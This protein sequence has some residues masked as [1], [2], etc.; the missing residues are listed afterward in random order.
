MSPSFLPH[1]LLHVRKQSK[2]LAS[3]IA[4]VRP[5]RIAVLRENTGRL[6][7]TDFLSLVLRLPDP[8]NAKCARERLIGFYGRFLRSG[9]CWLQ[10][11]AILRNAVRKRNDELPSVS[12][13]MQSSEMMRNSLG[14]N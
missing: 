5:P 11:S 7:T 10:N 2:L 14:L 4:D 12:N 9:I 1:H 3:Y 13:D 6:K 8:F